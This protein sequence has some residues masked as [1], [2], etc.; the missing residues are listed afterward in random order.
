M[1]ATKLC[2]TRLIQLPPAQWDVHTRYKMPLNKHC[3]MQV[4]AQ[5][6]WAEEANKDPWMGKTNEMLVDPWCMAYGRLC[7]HQFSDA[8]WPLTIDD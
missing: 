8:G 3:L 1:A 4:K 2:S 5:N 6:D 7:R